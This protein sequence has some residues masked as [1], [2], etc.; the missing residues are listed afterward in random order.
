MASSIS[1]V[2]KNSNK[3]IS[4]EESIIEIIS[5]K[6]GENGA[7]AKAAWHVKSMA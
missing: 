2:M 4:I 3:R 1:G 5:S 6:N 7:A